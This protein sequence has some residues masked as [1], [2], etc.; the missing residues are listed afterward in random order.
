MVAGASRPAGRGR[1][2][3][4]SPG[5]RSALARAASALAGRARSDGRRGIPACRPRSMQAATHGAATT[6]GRLTAFTA[7]GGAARV[8]WPSDP[9]A[10]TYHGSSDAWR[11]DDFRPVNGIHR[12][13][14]CGAGLLA[15]RSCGRSPRHA[16]QLVRPRK[17]SDGPRRQMPQRRR[18][19]TS[20][21]IQGPPIAKAC[22]PTRSAKKMVRRSAAT[23][24][25]AKAKS[26]F[27]QWT[28]DLRLI[29]QLHGSTY[30]P[31]RWYR[32]TQGGTGSPAGSSS[33]MDL[34][35]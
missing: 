29:A 9:A 6:S 14:R 15:V 23:D 12:H 22:W 24:A 5:Q 31:P 1:C 21:N 35:P 4:C 3:G 27:L 33:S 8:Y 13:G 11:G 30:L 32:R 34:G 19:R 10:R 7:M 18:S 17:W 28:L 25:P 16:G 2:K 20:C 26:Y